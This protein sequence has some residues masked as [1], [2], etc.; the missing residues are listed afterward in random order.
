[1]LSIQRHRGYLP[2]RVPRHREKPWNALPVEAILDCL[3]A[4]RVLSGI[5]NM[6]E[7]LAAFG[8]LLIHDPLERHT[9]ILGLRAWTDTCFKCLSAC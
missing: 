7:G 2:I 6:G 4:G 5:R 8:K 9:R 1:M 3:A